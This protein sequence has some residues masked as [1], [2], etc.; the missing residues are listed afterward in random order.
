MPCVSPLTWAYSG[1]GTR[2]PELQLSGLRL[3]AA[4]T[5]SGRWLLRNLT[6]GQVRHSMALV[7]CL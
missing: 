1:L 3:G 7:P 5:A 6:Q 2:E 4:G